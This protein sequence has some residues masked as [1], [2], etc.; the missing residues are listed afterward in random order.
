M[1]VA[2]TSRTANP[3]RYSPPVAR[4]AATNRGPTTAPAWS[5]ASW[6][7]KPQPWPSWWVACESIA[8]RAGVRMAL[9]TLSQIMSAAAISHRP[10]R[11]RRGTATMFRP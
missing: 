8:S 4:T 1:R 9:P 3:V 5:S 7:P 11:A 2:G 10:A 6:S